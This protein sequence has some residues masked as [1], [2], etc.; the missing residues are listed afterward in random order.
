[1]KGILLNDNHDM[2]INIKRDTN[3]FITQGFV[4]GD[5]TC[6]NQELIV[7]A[8]KGE[9]KSEPTKGVGIK[10]FLDDET[11]ENLIRNIRTELSLEGM[12]VNKIGFENG[13]LSID[14][15]YK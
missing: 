5:I 10:S 11:P 7:L 13:N 1:M 3:G 9:I 12:Q 8:E 4:I 14:A 2:Q 6:Q 15:N